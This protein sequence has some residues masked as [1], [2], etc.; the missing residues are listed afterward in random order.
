MKM[1]RRSLFGLGLGIAALVLASGASDAKL[2]IPRTNINKDPEPDPLLAYS[3]KNVQKINVGV[4]EAIKKWCKV[5]KVPL[6]ISLGV[7]K[8]ES[9]FNPKA[10]SNRHL[11]DSSKQAKGLYQLMDKT[12]AGLGVTDPFDPDQSAKAGNMMLASLFKRYGNWRDALYAY[13]WGV[14]NVDNN[15]NVPSRVHLYAQNVLN[16]AAKYV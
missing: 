2:P 7:V 6:H 14:G 9:N 10:V 15:E 12:A 16:A 8:V 3:T 4:F 11:K 13:N 5:Y 1:N